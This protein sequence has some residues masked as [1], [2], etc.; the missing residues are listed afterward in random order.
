MTRGDDTTGGGLERPAVQS[1]AALLKRQI[2]ACLDAMNA[3]ELEVIAELCARVDR[4]RRKYGAL[5]F[6]TDTRDFLDE[7]CEEQ[8]DGL[9]YV[10]GFLLR[11]KRR[12]L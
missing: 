9:W 2:T 1:R 7:F 5:N 4:A 12:R 11:R 10:V 6:A 3:D 8:V